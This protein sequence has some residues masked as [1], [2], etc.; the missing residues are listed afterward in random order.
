MY[1]EMIRSRVLVKLLHKKVVRFVF[2]GLFGAL[3]ELILFPLL[4]S[5]GFGIVFANVVAFHVAFALCFILHFSYTHSYSITEISLFVSGFIKYAALMYAQ[6]GLG[7]FLLWL[8][9]DKID[10]SP[11]FSKLLQIAIVTP[12]GYLIQRLVIFRRSSV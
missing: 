1:F 11:E 9:I 3:V 6:L 10:F 4:L 7:T 12:L 8:L 5:T 2:V